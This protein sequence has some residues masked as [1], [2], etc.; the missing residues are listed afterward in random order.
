MAA[1]LGDMKMEG[2]DHEGGFLMREKLSPPPG[3]DSEPRFRWTVR[4]EFDYKGLLGR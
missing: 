3:M 1:V 4:D 2:G